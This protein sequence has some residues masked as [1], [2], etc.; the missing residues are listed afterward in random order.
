MYTLVSA[1]GKEKN[2]SRR[3]KTANISDVTLHDLFLNYRKLLVLLQDEFME[4]PEVFDLDSIRLTHSGLDVTFSQFLIDNGNN[5]LE[6]TPG[7][8]DFKTT[9]AKYADAYRAGYSVD[10]VS[11]TGVVD[12]T[13]PKDDKTWLIL[14]KNGADYDL[15]GK[16]CLTIVN[17]FFHFSETNSSGLYI[18]DGAISSRICGHSTVGLLSFHGVSELRQIPITIDMIKQQ[19]DHPLHFRTVLDVGEDLS[20]KTVFLVIGGYL[21]LPGTR[22]FTLESETRILIDFNNYSIPNRFFESN[23]YLDYSSFELDTPMTNDSQYAMDELYSD[24]FVTSLLTMS[25]SF[26]VVLDN[27]DIFIEKEHVRPSPMPGIYTSYVPPIY[28]LFLGQGMAANYWYTY[29][30]PYWSI[31]TIDG[32]R[33]L[34]QYNTT[35]T[36]DLLSIDDSRVP[37]DPVHWSMAYYLK[38]SADVIG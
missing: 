9:Y 5:T 33:H 14:R 13:E 2:D 4:E 25:Q 15:I 21:V 35:K 18:K 38:I 28:P 12:S 24:E 30:K 26:I 16:H 37:G 32:L 10:L 31:N 3:W 19:A 29:Q 36:R 1:I 11:Q 23:K 17:G 7:T 22:V 27:P 6:T 20:N 34:R 8:L